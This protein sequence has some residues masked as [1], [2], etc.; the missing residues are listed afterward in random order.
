[1]CTQT[2]VLLHMFAIKYVAYLC[3]NTQNVYKKFKLPIHL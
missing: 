3:N 1:M 2:N